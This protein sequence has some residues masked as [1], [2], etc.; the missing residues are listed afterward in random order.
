VSY[1]YSM[2]WCV[3]HARGRARGGGVA[4]NVRAV[5]RAAQSERARARGGGH[6]ID[7][8][9]ATRPAHFYEILHL[10]S[11]LGTLLLPCA[12]G[13]SIVLFLCRYT[14]KFHCAISEANHCSCRS[15]SNLSVHS[16]SS[17]LAPC[18]SASGCVERPPTSPFPAVFA[19][20]RTTPNKNGEGAR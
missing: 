1:F 8:R 7:V 15:T 10:G 5:T 16:S 18:R 14:M 9:A 17:T 12:P 2:S 3:L 19:F 11:Y 20:A 6:A 4:I 13:N